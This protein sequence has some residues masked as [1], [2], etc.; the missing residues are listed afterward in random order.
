MMSLQAKTVR[1]GADAAGGVKEIYEY[2]LLGIGLVK[3]I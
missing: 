1:A 3:I 2:L